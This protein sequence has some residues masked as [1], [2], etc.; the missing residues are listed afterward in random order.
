MELKGR[1][2][3]SKNI[4]GNLIQKII[5]GIISVGSVEYDDFLENLLKELS[6]IVGGENQPYNVA[7]LKQRLVD[8]IAISNETTGSN[9]T[10]LT[11]AMQSLLNGYCSRKCVFEELLEDSIIEVEGIL[12]DDII[13]FENYIIE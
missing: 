6:K 11:S 7:E 10:D 1:I 12:I 4:S 2:N 9:D 13:A 3:P 8:L 5:Q